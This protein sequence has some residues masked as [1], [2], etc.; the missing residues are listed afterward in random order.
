MYREV[1]TKR[2]M[3]AFDLQK[4]LLDVAIKQKPITPRSYR[5]LEKEGIKIKQKKKFKEPIEEF[6]FSYNHYDYSNPSDYY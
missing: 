1:N 4:T 6:K 5:K 3:E 2:S